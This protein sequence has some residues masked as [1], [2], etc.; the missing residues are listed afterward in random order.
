MNHL[1]ENTKIPKPCG[2]NTLRLLRKLLRLTRK[3]SVVVWKVCSNFI[4]N[5][6]SNLDEGSR[7]RLGQNQRLLISITTLRHSIK[8]ETCGHGV[9][10]YGIEYHIIPCTHFGRVQ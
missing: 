8:R 10:A 4:W 7:E 9:C 6:G 1:V 5:T 3:S 2:R